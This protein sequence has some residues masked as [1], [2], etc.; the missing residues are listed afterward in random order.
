MRRSEAK[1]RSTLRLVGQQ[2]IRMKDHEPNEDQTSPVLTGEP[3][4][5]PLENTGPIPAELLKDSDPYESVPWSIRR[6][7]T[8][9]VRLVWMTVL[10]VSLL[11]SA[12]ALLRLMLIV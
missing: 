5:S 3:E 8:R 11:V 9:R 7:E 1:I 10:I 4:E 2:V 6:A 12:V